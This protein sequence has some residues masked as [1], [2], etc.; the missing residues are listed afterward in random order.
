MRR[1]LRIIERTKEWNATY[2]GSDMPVFYHPVQ[3]LLFAL[4]RNGSGNGIERFVEEIKILLEL[5]YDPNCCVPDYMQGN[6]LHYVSQMTSARKHERFKMQTIE[7]LINHGATVY[8]NVQYHPYVH[9]CVK[10]KEL[11]RQRCITLAFTLK[12]WIPKDVIKEIVNE[13]FVS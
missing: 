13:S 3:C 4:E 7:L 9:E 6:M 11:R 1:V 5:G 10:Q 8:S 2:R 12:K